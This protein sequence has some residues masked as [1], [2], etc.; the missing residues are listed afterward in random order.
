MSEFK[1]KTT[2]A[3]LLR[4]TIVSAKSKIY[5]PR[6]GYLSP[7]NFIILEI[8]ATLLFIG[9]TIFLLILGLI[10]FTLKHSSNR[11]VYFREPFLLIE[12]Y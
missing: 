6:R 7:G 2:I 4:L 1:A 10:L 11:P 3:Q 9:V 12:H 5:S 8:A